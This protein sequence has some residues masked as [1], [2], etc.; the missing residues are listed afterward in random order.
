ML[1]SDKVRNQIKIK[2]VK[3]VSIMT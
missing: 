2:M 3:N 1:Y